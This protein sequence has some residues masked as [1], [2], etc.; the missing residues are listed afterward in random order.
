MVVKVKVSLLRIEVVVVVVQAAQE[1][2]EVHQ[3]MGALERQYQF[4]VQQR[5]MQVVGVEVLIMP[6]QVLVGLQ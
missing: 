4:Q 1:L 6:P 3:E 5:L 2:L